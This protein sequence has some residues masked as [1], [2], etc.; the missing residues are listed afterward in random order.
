[1]SSLKDRLKD[2]FRDVME[3]AEFSP[4]V[5]S[6]YFHP[7]YMQ[8]VDGKVLNFEEFVQHMK[9]L[10]SKVSQ[11]KI[12]FQHLVEEGDTVCSLHFAEGKKTNN[13]MVKMKVIAF[14]KFRKDKLILC[15]ELT[16][17]IHGGKED[18]NLG[19]DT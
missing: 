7:D 2:M 14:F 12:H 4:S 19:S 11:V 3:S 9:H 17:M 18:K 5:I 8:H 13:Q 16:F 6:E 15:D 1:M 10:R